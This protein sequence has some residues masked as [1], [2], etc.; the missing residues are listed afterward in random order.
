MCYKNQ[1]FHTVPAIDRYWPRGRRNDPHGLAQS[2]DAT[3]G[4][5]LSS[6]AGLL[7]ALSRYLLGT[8]SGPLM[9]PFFSYPV[10]A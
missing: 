9:A 3:L 8:G 4:R 6:P 1:V 10:S 5:K 2:S 7:P